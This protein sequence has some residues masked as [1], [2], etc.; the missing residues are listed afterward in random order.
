MGSTDFPFR[1]QTNRLL[2]MEEGPRTGGWAA[3]LL[4]A[5]ANVALDELD[6]AWLLTTPDGPIPFSPPLEDDFLPGPER[7]AATVLERLEVAA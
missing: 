7:I 2:A 3:G 1:L 4:G 5:L 6:D